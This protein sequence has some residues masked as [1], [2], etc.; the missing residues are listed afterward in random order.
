[1]RY[2]LAAV[3]ILACALPSY[4]QAGTPEQ[5]PQ[6]TTPE[7][8][9][10]APSNSSQQTPA[11]PAAPPS[12]TPAPEQPEATPPANPEPAQVEPSKPEGSQPSSSNKSVTPTTKKK[13]RTHKPKPKPKP[14]T[15]PPTT[16]PE[17][18]VVRNGST[19]EPEVQFSPRL[20][21]KQ[22]VDQ[23]EKISNLLSVTDANLQKVAGRPLKVSEEEMMKQ[24]RAYM[25]QAKQAGETGDLQ[26]AQ[27]LASKANLLS[28]ELVGK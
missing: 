4:A 20:T 14:A 13:P 12:T 22:Q 27:N 17:K 19:S 26:R 8:S 7:Q 1:M 5:P 18:T 24:I 21:E 28:V 2:S 16:S 10:P 6:Q 25:E 11:P 23:K 3:A 15:D 9:Q